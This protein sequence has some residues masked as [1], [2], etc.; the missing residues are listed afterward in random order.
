MEKLKKK[1]VW[2]SI[3]SVIVVLCLLFCMIPTAHAENSNQSLY[4]VLGDSISTGYGL[5]NADDA[6][7]KKV[8]DRISLERSVLAV[9]GQTTTSLLESVSSIDTPGDNIREAIGNAGLI[10]LT[11]GGNDI[12]DALYKYLT[13]KYNEQNPNNTKDEEQIKSELMSGQMFT[14]LFALGVIS[15]FT[16]SSEATE[17]FVNISANLPLIFNKIKEINPDAVV[18]MTTQYNPYGFLAKELTGTMFGTY[19]ETISNT[20]ETGVST[21]NNIINT[22]TAQYGYI[23]ADVYSAFVSAQENPCNAS[24]AADTMAFNLDFHPNA[25]GHELIANVINS[26]LPSSASV[27]PESIYFGNFTEGYLSIPEKKFTIKNTG[28]QVLNNISVIIRGED[29]DCFGLDTN[30]TETSLVINSDTEFIVSAKPDCPPGEYSATVEISA[31]GIE[32]IYRAVSFK[33]SEQIVVTGIEDGGVYCESVEV[34][35]TGENFKGA[36]V[37]GEDVEVVDNKFVIG[38]SSDVRTVIFTDNSGSSITYNITVNYEHQCEIINEKEPTCTEEG[39]SGDVIC[40]NCGDVIEKGHVLEK[41]DHKYENGHCIYC[42]V[43][44]PKYVKGDVNLDGEINVYDV[45]LIQMFISSF[46]INDT[47]IEELADIN[48]DKTIT[49]Y[50]A[51]LIQ[52]MIARNTN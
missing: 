16:T 6:F 14:V 31:D 19:A 36:A 52:I 5:E 34:T 27:T 50:D 13:N 24:F 21:L 48:G 37:D 10:T 3:L 9:D 35:V 11:I 42:G 23:T 18:V 22:V 28:Y 51:T 17:A 40:A 2:K 30:S 33:V 39:Y 29:K 32:T 8:A 49:I 25:Y 44:D 46:D 15:D 41:T 43:Q 45:T 7:S 4:V 20:F 1:A 47:F 38:P 12:M 26:V